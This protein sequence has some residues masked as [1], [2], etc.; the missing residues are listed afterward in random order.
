MFCFC[1]FRVLRLFFTSNSVVC[2]GGGACLMRKGPD[3]G[4]AT[5]YGTS[6]R[7]QKN[8]VIDAV[9]ELP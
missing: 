3:N 7:F 4:Y 1:N 8:D 2:V 6:K 9:T 5:D